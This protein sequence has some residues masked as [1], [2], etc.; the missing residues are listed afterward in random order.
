LSRAPRGPD[1]ALAALRPGLAAIQPHR[2]PNARAPVKLNQNE[3]PYDL[4]ASVKREAVAA[5]EAERWSRY[6]VSPAAQVME[7]LAAWLDHPRE[8]L[9]VTHGSNEALAVA[10]QAVLEPGRRCVY[11]VPG[12][13]LY[14]QLTLLAGAEPVEVPLA[15]GLSVDVACFTE[16]AAAGAD[17]IVFSSPHN[18]TG[19]SLSAD[20]LERVVAA[21]N[22]IVL[23]DEAYAEF[24]GTSFSARTLTE[25]R[26]L[27]ARS[28]SKGLRLAALRVGY[29]V[30]HPAVIERMRAAQLPH[31][32]DLL[33]QI[34]AMKVLDRIG[35]LMP[36]IEEVRSERERMRAA[37]ATRP[38]L[39]VH[40]SDANFLLVQLE[41]EDSGSAARAA[42]RLA[43][44]GILIRDVSAGPPLGAALRIGVGTAEENTRVLEALGRALGAP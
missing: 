23:V 18:P 13:P 25:P 28:F 3:N 4:P 31:T 30:G 15:A 16:E 14:R 20:D 10:F 7:R 27:V 1:A 35:E 37:L 32:V 39:R 22:G 12:F 19:R 2:A 36:V 6:P 38:G 40:P 42:A 8:G 41:N 43:E 11:T 44:E 24:A 5:L 29:V 9:L 33:G 26:L 21:G 34:G 17:L